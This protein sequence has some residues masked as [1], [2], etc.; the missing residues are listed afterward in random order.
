MQSGS[1]SPK[2]A[3]G[4]AGS[5]DSAGAGKDPANREQPAT[6]SSAINETTSARVMRA[7]RES[8][9]GS[10]AATEPLAWVHMK[11]VGDRFGGLDVHGMHELNR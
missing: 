10:S 5:G 1:S 11:A 3:I 8:G 9:R 6:A 2:Q 4:T 7:G